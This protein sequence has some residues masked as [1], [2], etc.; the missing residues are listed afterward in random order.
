MKSEVFCS[1]SQSIP[2]LNDENIHVINEPPLCEN[3]IENSRRKDV[4]RAAREDHLSDI[5]CRK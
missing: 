3:V 4:C 5:I 2:E 1:I